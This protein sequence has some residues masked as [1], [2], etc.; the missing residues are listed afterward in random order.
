MKKLLLVLALFFCG[1]STGTNNVQD[2]VNS[3]EEGINTEEETIVL[4]EQT[5]FNTLVMLLAFPAQ[6]EGYEVTM[7][8]QIDKIHYHENDGFFL[9]RTVV[10]CCLEDAEFMG[11]VCLN[12]DAGTYAQGDWVV[13]QGTFHYTDDNVRELIDT[14]ITRADSP[15]EVYIYPS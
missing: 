9:G 7:F 5:Y 1:C 6:Y 2:T 12:E 10:T 3:T 4:N 8:G 14:T 15:K 11:L 13:V